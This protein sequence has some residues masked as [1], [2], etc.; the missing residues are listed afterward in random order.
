VQPESSDILIIGGGIGGLALALALKQFGLRAVVCERTAVLKEVGAGLLLTPNA[1]W[2]LHQLGLLENLSAKAHVVRTWQILDK[3][4]RLLQQF[5]S[6]AEDV[7]SI[8]TARAVLQE[9]L[10]AQISP[11]DLLLG[12]SAE[13]VVEG[14]DGTWTVRFSNGIVRKCRLLIGADGGRSVIREKVFSEAPP[15]YCGYVGWR[16]IVDEVPS[17]WGREV[18]AESW[19]AGCRFGIAPISE[20]RTYWYS[21]ENVPSGWSIPTGERKAYLLEKFGGWHDPIRALIQATPEDRI[22]LNDISDHS[23]LPRWHR[24]RVALL[25]DAAHLMSPNLGQGA[26][27]ALED[28]WVLARC[29][30][31]YGL[32]ERAL[33]EYEKLRKWRVT[34]VVWQSR[35]LGRLIQLENPVLWRLRNFGLWLTP[36]SIGALSLDSVF[37]FRA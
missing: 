1:T 6:K 12:Y 36:D 15:R 2:I 7:P 33:R 17:G 30:A 19:G 3:S 28:A 23:T 13:N 20:S 8:N 14:T 26:A 4:G 16:A 10:V 5:R 37:N 22:L 34:R 25:G 27:M 32:S 35:Q 9:V 11:G 18:V 24:D 31:K 29:L 21:T